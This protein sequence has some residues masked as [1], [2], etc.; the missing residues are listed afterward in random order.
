MQNKQ[1]FLIAMLV[2]ALP[3][4]LSAQEAGESVL[5]RENVDDDFYAAGNK[6][7]LEGD[8]SGDAVLA[9]G[10]VL[11][12]GAVSEDVIAAG[13]TVTVLGD[14]GDDLRLAGG[15]VT[16]AASVADHAVI[17]GGEVEVGENATINSWA[18]LAGGEVEMNGWVTGDLKIAAG[19]AEIS[20]RVDGDVEI[21]ASEIEIEDGAVINGNLIWRG[22]EEPE[23]SG[24]AE[25]TG[26]V[27]EGEPFEGF[28]FE[29]DEGGSGLFGL[30]SI[31]F[32]AGL[33]YTVFS[34]RLDRLFSDFVS[35]PGRSLLV[36]LGVLVFMPVLAALF[37][38]TAIGW[39]LGLLV[40]AA[41]GLI[42]VTGA[43]TG[44]SLTARWGLDR[45]RQMPDPNLGMVWLAIAALAVVITV[46]YWIPLLGGVAATAILLL[47]VGSVARELFREV[48]EK[49]AA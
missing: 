45:F 15:Q 46:L 38:A 22:E 1:L 27:I 30:L 2:T 20:G 41:Y 19:E 5:V 17:S 7:V 28:E 25:I 44:I 16:L 49:A 11:I 40:F 39:L 4:A 26:E 47:G 32:S 36:G 35:Q 31:I 18:W 37:F 34:I 33:F 3:A 48:R 43:L 42:V 29:R 8:V 12:T 23:I 6:V 10:T 14:V 13:G 24:G 9:G 21:F